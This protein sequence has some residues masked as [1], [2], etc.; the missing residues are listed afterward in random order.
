MCHIQV[1]S[2][3]AFP[4]PNTT[5][6]INFYTYDALDQLVEV[7]HPD[8]NVVRYS[9]DK[10]G[11]RTG[12]TYPDGKVAVYDYDELN[13][14]V[15]VNGLGGQTSYYYDAASNLRRITYP[16]NTS[17]AYRYD[18]ADRLVEVAN[19]RNEDILAR[20]RYTLDELGNHRAIAPVA[21]R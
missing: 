4:N 10:V 8:G 17:I 2:L 19:K 18:K 12:L 3:S 16:N 13:R 6:L 20:F 7:I 11:N 5:K 1:L 14:L 21:E 9:Y 15:R